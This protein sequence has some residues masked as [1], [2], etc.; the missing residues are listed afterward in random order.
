MLQD[1]QIAQK[2]KNYQLN[3]QKTH[4]QRKSV[5]TRSLNAFLPIL[6]HFKKYYFRKYH[7]AIKM[8]HAKNV[9]VEFYQT[10]DV[11]PEH[12]NER[13]RR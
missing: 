9:A 11:T 3:H 5:S 2:T 1:S 13:I 4:S 10:S 6:H 7:H 8:M 12:V